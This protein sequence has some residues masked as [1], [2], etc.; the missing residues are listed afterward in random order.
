MYDANSLL[1]LSKAMDLFDFEA[2]MHPWPKCHTL[3][4]GIQSDLLFPVHQQRELAS[5]L[6]SHGN[7][8]VTYYELDSIYGH[9]TFLID[10]VNIGAAI[11]GHLEG[12]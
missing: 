12:S 10:V 8:S 2:S 3:V 9:D 6:R 4:L 1:Y 11:K 5:L 7:Q